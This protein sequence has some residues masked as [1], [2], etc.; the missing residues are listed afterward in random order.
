MPPATVRR[1]T[2]AVTVLAAIWAG[3]PPAAAD[4]PDPTSSATP[5]PATTTALATTVTPSR[6]ATLLDHRRHDRR[7]GDDVSYVVT[8]AKT[9]TVIAARRPDR[10][11]QPASNMKIITATT[12]LATLGADHRWRTRVVLVGSD[13]GRRHV[14][15][16]GAGDPLLS[17]DG[18]RTLAR[19]AARALG[20]GA[21]IVVH[22]DASL[23]PTSRLAPG[24]I[25]QFIGSSVGYVRSLT[26][27]SDRSRTPAKNVVRLFAATLRASGRAAT[28]GPQ[29]KT[30]ADARVI[31]QAPGHTVAEAVA[32]MLQQS[33][34]SIAE[35]LFRQVALATGRPATW[36][37]GQQAVR[38]VLADLGVAAGD[39][40]L[41]DG[42]GLS[43]DDRVTV[44]LV[45]RVL[46]VTRYEQRERFS[47]M[48]RRDAMPIAGRTGTLRP[49]Y[50]RYS[51][52]P[53]KCARAD[54]QAKTGTILQTIALSGIARTVFGGQRV[55][56]VIVNHRPTRIDRLSTRRAVDGLAATIVGCWR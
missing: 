28:T 9:G 54:V 32:V 11:M 48:F 42:S 56:S 19:K 5:A 51:T 7:L 24:W 41:L 20:P 49:A 10:L 23:F 53:S 30:P 17:A 31:A 52:Q 12:A 3:L 26:M 15:V 21:P 25:P 35:M 8:D 27:R 43:R 55:F 45:A 4:E 47:A 29:H 22:P 13:D 18:V 2:V 6:L 1:L 40:R 16:V 37:G 46:H 44:R 39:A 50:G 38:A 34:S 14:A 33:D 36:A